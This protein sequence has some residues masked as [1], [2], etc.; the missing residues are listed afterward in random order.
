[1]GN[2]IID[3]FKKGLIDPESEDDDEAY[4]EYK[5]KQEEKARREVKT[6]AAKSVTSRPSVSRESSF[7]SDLDRQE[8]ELAS[9]SPIRPV[10]NSYRPRPE[11][12]RS[13]NVIQHQRTPQGS[14]ISIMKPNCFEDALDICDQ[15]NGNSAVVINLEGADADLAQRVVDFVCG[16]LYVQEGN[17]RQISDYILIV[18]PKSFDISGDYIEILAQ[19][20]GFGV[21]EFKNE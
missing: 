5:V 19:G 2:R 18:A 13:G 3:F 20:S 21:P 12:T 7:E 6:A 4:E 1:M 9:V 15:L 10:Q 8:Q 14:E 16:A 17:L 11:R